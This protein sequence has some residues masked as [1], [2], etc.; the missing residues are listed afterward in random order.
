MV[1]TQKTQPHVF[2]M[3]L[4]YFVFFSEDFN[5]VLCCRRIIWLG[6]LNYRIA[7]NYAEARKLLEDNNWDALFEKDQVLPTS[8]HSVVTHVKLKAFHKNSVVCNNVNRKS[9]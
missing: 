3:F 6:D 5:F 2:I 9:Q 4:L 8:F 7:L 1:K